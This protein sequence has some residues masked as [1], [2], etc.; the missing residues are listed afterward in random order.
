[1]EVI[2]TRGVM[3]LNSGVTPSL[4]LL[5]EPNR[6]AANRTE[7]WVNWT[8]GVEP[9]TEAQ[10]EG[11]TGYDAAHR[12]LVRDWLLAID[13]KREPLASGERAMKAIEMAHGVFLSG[14]ESRRID[15]PLVRRTHPL[16]AA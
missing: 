6:T 3:R 9:T 8:G 12:R 1:M 13:E 14:I 16:I 2:G 11:L 15:F 10:F 4:S 5:A 7:N